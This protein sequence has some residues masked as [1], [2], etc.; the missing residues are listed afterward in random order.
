MQIYLTA[1]QPIAALIEKYQNGPPA[2]FIV[3]DIIELFRDNDTCAVDNIDIAAD[4]KRSGHAK[5]FYVISVEE[6]DPEK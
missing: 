6:I 5:Y 3:E 4:K 2:D 1:N